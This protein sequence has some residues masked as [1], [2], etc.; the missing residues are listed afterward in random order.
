VKKALIR[1][2]VRRRP[3]EFIRVHPGEDCRLDTAIIDLRDDAKPTECRIARSGRGR[4]SALDGAR[5]SSGRKR[6]VGAAGSG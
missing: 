5:K 4:Q 6:G 1:V 3:Q 2:P